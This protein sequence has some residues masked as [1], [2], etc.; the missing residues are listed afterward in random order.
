[1][2]K[3][4]VQG[5]QWITALAT[6]EDRYASEHPR[7]VALGRTR[8]W[9]D[10]IYRFNT[11]AVEVLGVTFTDLALGRLPAKDERSAQESKLV[12]RLGVEPDASAVRVRA[13]PPLQ[14]LP[15]EDL[16][17]KQFEAL[18]AA[19]VEFTP[20][21]V[22]CHLYGVE[23]EKQQGIDIVAIRRADADKKETWVYQCKRQKHFPPGDVRK[24]FSKIA[25]GRYDAEAHYRVLMLSIPATAPMRE[26]VPKK[27][28]CF[29]WDSFDLSRKLK[30]YPVLVEEFFRKENRDVFC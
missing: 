10:L 30:N 3:Q 17:P 18:C 16:E 4:A 8:E 29:I 11:L 25:G 14:V 1:V 19:L 21:T 13:H 27:D 12:R 23:G 2:L 22:E 20:G 28:S 26:A 7:M 15:F 9:D 6:L 24:A 5:S